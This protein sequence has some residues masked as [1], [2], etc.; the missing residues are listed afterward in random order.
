M[1]VLLPFE[2][3]D[4]GHWLQVFEVAEYEFVMALAEEVALVVVAWLLL[5]A[6]GSEQLV[7]YSEVGWTGLAVGY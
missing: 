4:I 6:V 7:Q 3:E 2:V 5:V 1:R